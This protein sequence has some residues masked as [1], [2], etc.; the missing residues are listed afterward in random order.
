[1]QKNDILWSIHLPTYSSLN[2]IAESRHHYLVETI[3]ALLLTMHKLKFCD[4]DV[5]I[6]GFDKLNSNFF[7]EQ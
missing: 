5:L 3:C 2:V 4:D 1:M 6:V 7:F